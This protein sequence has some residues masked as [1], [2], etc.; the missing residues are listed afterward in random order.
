VIGIAAAEAGLKE[1]IAHMCP[2]ARWL[3]ENVPS[4]P[5]DKMLA[6]YWQDLPKMP[7]VNGRKLRIPRRLIKDIKRGIELRNKIVHTGKWEYHGR[8]LGQILAAVRDILHILDCAQGHFWAID[9]VRVEVA[10]DIVS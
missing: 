7:M 10:K 4:P 9:Y 5:I 6:Q 8:G 3:L 2:D 1:C